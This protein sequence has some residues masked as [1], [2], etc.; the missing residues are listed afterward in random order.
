MM[1]LLLK[2]TCTLPKTNIFAPEH[3]WLEDEI[4]TWDGL[5]LEAMLVS[6]EGI[7]LAILLVTFLGCQNHTWLG[8]F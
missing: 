6:R 7:F 1:L 4:S 8:E 2:K 5:F 3:G